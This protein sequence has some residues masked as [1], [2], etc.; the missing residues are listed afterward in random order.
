MT[1][2]IFPEASHIMNLLSIL[3]GYYTLTYIKYESIKI[4]FIIF[5]I[6]IL[7]F[8][9]SGMLLKFVQADTYRYS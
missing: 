2:L 8:S 6:I 3:L 5:G 7:L 9:L 1:I 4:Y